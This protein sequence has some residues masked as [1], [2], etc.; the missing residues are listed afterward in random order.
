MWGCFSNHERGGNAV[1]F[2]L[3]IS[4]KNCLFG[5]LLIVEA[6]AKLVGT[7]WFW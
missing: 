1:A 5:L 7:V 6:I 3:S 2:R 4:D